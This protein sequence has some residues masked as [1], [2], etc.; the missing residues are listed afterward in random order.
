LIDVPLVSLASVPFDV[1]DRPSIV[2]LTPYSII[3]DSPKHNH[4]E[5]QGGP[6]EVL[7]IGIRCDGEEHEDEQWG[8]E[9]EGAEVRS[10]SQ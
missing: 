10:I 5:D 3:P 2:F 6:I 4:E 1:C 9:R 8:L 7:G